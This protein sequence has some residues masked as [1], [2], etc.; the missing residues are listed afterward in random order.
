MKNVEATRTLLLLAEQDP[1][2]LQVRTG[3]SFQPRQC[4]CPKPLPWSSHDSKSMSGWS[5]ASMHQLLGFLFQ[6]KGKVAC[7]PLAT[8]S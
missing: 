3:Q 5:C 1:D 2:A 6:C 8:S 7:S 4:T